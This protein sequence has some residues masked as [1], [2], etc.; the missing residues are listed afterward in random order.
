MV[1]GTVKQFYNALYEMKS[2]YPFDDE[3]TQICT[4]N[5]YSLAENQLSIVT[6]DEKTGITIQMSKP[7]ER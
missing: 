1:G 4:R 5:E 6:V 7:I 3:K 2:I